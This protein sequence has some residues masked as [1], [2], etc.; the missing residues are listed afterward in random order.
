MPDAGKPAGLT[1]EYADQFADRAVAQAYRHREPYCEEVFILLAEL[2]VVPQPRVLD[3]GCGSGDLTLGLSRFAGHI[4]AVDTSAAMIDEAAR[5]SMPQP[6][7]RF[8]VGAAERVE[9]EGPYDLVTAAQSLHWMDWPV[10][11]GRLQS[12]LR[13]GGVLAIVER[14]YAHTA[15]RD[16]AFR[17]I[18]ARYSTNQDYRAYDLVSELQRRGHLEPLGSARKGPIAFRQSPRDFVEAMHSRNGFSRERM[19]PED[20]LAFDEA[21]NRHMERF[22]E[23]GSLD[24]GAVTHV[25]WG[26]P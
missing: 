26:R 10:V 21:M 12:S 7:V 9:L 1:S 8:I 2:A 20:A 17:A 4:D 5:R 3:L 19:R 15:W 24:L 16:A 23:S 14:D 22:A 18:V 6:N 25:T 11:F 13:S